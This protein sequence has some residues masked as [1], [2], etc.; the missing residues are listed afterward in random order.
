MT[1]EIQR[2]H[3]RNALDGLVIAQLRYA[4]EALTDAGVRA[5]VLTGQG[6]FFCSGIDADEKNCTWS[7]LLVDELLGEAVA[8]TRAIGLCPAP[9]IAAVNGPAIGVGLQLAA[10]CDQRIVDPTA[11]FQLPA[12]NYG[13]IVDGWATRR[14]STLV[15]V[16]RSRAT[17]LSEQKL[18]ADEALACGLASR[19]GTVADAQRSAHQ[20]ASYFQ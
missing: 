4:F 10:I 2:P 18:S 1:I 7:P 6:S 12:T 16:S 8:L 3:R 20:I 11:Y 9:V 14:L 17:L 13:R 19:I 15:G 5:V